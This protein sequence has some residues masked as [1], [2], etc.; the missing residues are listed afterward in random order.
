MHL[1][2]LAW[3]IVDAHNGFCY[4]ANCGLD[5]YITHTMNWESRAQI[6]LLPFEMVED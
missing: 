3:L 4:N 1:K 5:R 2:T 6:V